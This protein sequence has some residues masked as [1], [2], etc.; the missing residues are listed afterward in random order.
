MNSER[1]LLIT[2]FLEEYFTHNKFWLNFSPWC[3]FWEFFSFENFWLLKN[4][5]TPAAVCFYRRDQ[6][7]L[8]SRQFLCIS[9]W[10]L[11]LAVGWGL[12][13]HG[14]KSRLVLQN[15]VLETQKKTK[16]HINILIL[17]PLSYN[18]FFRGTFYLIV[19]LAEF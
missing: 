13:G 10:L 15:P 7:T 5:T 6:G 11:G 8:Y 3:W 12:R 1:T 9:M 4:R 2:V 16:T 14:F 19:S 18:S 17:R